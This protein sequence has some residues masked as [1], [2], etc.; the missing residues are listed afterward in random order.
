MNPT[1]R[2]WPS[3]RLL[4]RLPPHLLLLL[5]PHLLLL[6]PQLPP[7]CQCRGPCSR[8]SSSATS[9]SR[10]DPLR[11]HHISIT[12]QALPMMDY[13]C[14]CVCVCVRARAR[15]RARLSHSKSLRGSVRD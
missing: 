10:C 12:R 7:R 4:L 11:R 3:L 6:L 8:G 15:A 13:V 5:P 9:S 2:L 14:V 1:T